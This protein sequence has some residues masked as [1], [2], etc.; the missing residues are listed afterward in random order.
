MLPQRE[1]K[2]PGATN[3]ILPINWRSLYLWRLQSGMLQT[4]TKS[5]ISPLF[6]AIHRRT[7]AVPVFEVPW[8]AHIFMHGIRPV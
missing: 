8:Y 4:M 3:N 7:P 1:K 5:H 2:N 6:T